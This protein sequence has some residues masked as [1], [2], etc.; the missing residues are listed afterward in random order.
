VKK[1]ATRGAP[2]KLAQA[3]TKLKL[4]DVRVDRKEW[5]FSEC[6]K[7]QLRACFFYEFARECP[8]AVD[9]ARA[10]RKHLKEIGADSVPDYRLAVTVVDLF[11]DCPEFPDTPFLAIPTAER[12]RRIK[13]L[14]KV[15]PPVQVDLAGLI[16]RYRSQAI[17][18]KTIKYGQGDI[19]G[20]YLDWTISDEKLIEGLR[21][22][23][24]TNRPHGAVATVRKGQGSSSQQIRKDLKALGAWRLVK[25]MKIGW[26]DA[27]V[28]TRE[29][30]KIKKGQP[31]G[32]FGSHANA[33]RRAQKD[34]EKIIVS[35]CAFLERHTI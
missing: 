32:L 9:A 35:I 20:F 10:L 8:H 13:K 26:E 34:A 3:I 28:Y 31:Q 4:D 5:D 2:A 14:G 21:H 24:K 7:D 27:F 19:A 12:H 17:T 18:G 33:W 22:S 29:I 23:L 1:S 25:K 15:I 6:P 30:L 16:R 11:K